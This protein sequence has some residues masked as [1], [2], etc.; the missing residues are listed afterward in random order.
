MIV[1]KLCRSKDECK[2]L[3]LYLS[4]H[5][6]LFSDWYQ[7]A[8]LVARLRF[9]PDHVPYLVLLR[10]DVIES[11]SSSFVEQPVGWKSVSSR[12]KNL[13]LFFGTFQ[14]S[15]ALVMLH[16]S[17]NDWIELKKDILIDSSIP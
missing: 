1:I 4:S 16:D 6:K 14:F 2:S 17:R 13:I 5:D 9:K 7:D 12:G 3:E 15:S 8:H 10:L 11:V